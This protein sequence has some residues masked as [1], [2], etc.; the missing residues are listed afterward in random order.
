MAFVKKVWKSRISEY[1]NRRILTDGEGTQTRYTV[2]RDEGVISQEGDAFSK[3]NMDD[4]ETRIDSA[5]IGEHTFLTGILTAGAT[6]IDFTDESIVAGCMPH[7]YVPMEKSKLIYNSMT[8][9]NTHT[10]RLTFPAQNT[11]TTIKVKIEYD[12]TPAQA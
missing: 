6:T 7:V 2:T 11:D 8:I 9:V 12:Q 4:L 5:F 1:P 10:L 3:A